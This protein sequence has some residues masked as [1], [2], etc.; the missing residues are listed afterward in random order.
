MKFDNPKKCN[1]VSCDMI[2]DNFLTEQCSD[3]L[4]SITHLVPDFRTVLRFGDLRIKPVN[5]N[6]ERYVRSR[7]PLMYIRREIIKLPFT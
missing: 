7:A 3:V 2:I 4:L 6:L 5:F 1:A